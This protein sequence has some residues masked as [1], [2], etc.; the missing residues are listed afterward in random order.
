MVETSS[1][2]AHRKRNEFQQ[3][4]VVAT[5]RAR[6]M[7]GCEQCFKPHDPAAPSCNDGY[8]QARWRQ[9]NALTQRA[10]GGGPT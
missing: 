9:Q 1:Q 5:E 7:G 4:L 3:V 6:T 10:K 2:L 8:C